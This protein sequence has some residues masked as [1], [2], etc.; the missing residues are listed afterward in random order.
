MVHAWSES[1]A[2]GKINQMR[3]AEWA[4][5]LLDHA[6]LSEVAGVLSRV[7]TEAERAEFQSVAYEARPLLIAA[8]Y[9]K[10]RDADAQTKILLVTGSH[11][12]ALA[13]QAKLTLCGV[14]PGDITLL[15]SG[16]S[17]LFEDAAPEHIALSDRLGALRSLADRSAG[18]IIATPQAALE[19]TL[20]KEVIQDAFVE[21]TQ[22][23]VL[24]VDGF[25]QRL[26]NLGY[27]HQE[28]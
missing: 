6:A 5:R 20:P 28:P 11:D 10:W 7:P 12:R 25:I 2:L 1:R 19:R 23:D 8:A 15:P 27:E 9:S 3:V 21:V 16:T 13:W 17:A 22:G 26:V 18:I 4:R 24:D 14:P